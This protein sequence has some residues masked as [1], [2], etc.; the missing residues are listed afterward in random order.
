MAK[1]QRAGQCK[2]PSHVRVISKTVALAPSSKSTHPLAGQKKALPK[3]KSKKAV[4]DNSEAKGKSVKKNVPTLAKK[5]AETALEGKSVAK[6]VTTTLAET[7]KNIVN[8]EKIVKKVAPIKTV[9][10]SEKA[11]SSKILA[12]SASTTT[13]VISTPVLPKQVAPDTKL[14]GTKSSLSTGRPKVV[15]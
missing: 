9:K 10:E 14:P 2:S 15:K 3:P 11:T 1:N 6:A 12:T 13:A 5:T 7:T 8:N 4:A